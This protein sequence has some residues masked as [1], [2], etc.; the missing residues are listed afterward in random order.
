MKFSAYI[1]VIAASALLCAPVKAQDHTVSISMTG[2]TK[3]EIP[4]GEIAKIEF[5]PRS[6]PKGKLK[7]MWID[8]EANFERLTTRAAID[9]ELNK[10]KS[11]GYAMYRSDFLPYCDVFGDKS[12]TR[13]YDDYLGYFL[14]R[15]EAI[16]LD[17]VASMGA[18]CWGVQT[19]N[20]VRQGLIFDQWDKWGD[21]VQVR[22]DE[23]NP[24]LIV[25]ITD[26]LSQPLALLDP[27]FPEV[28]ELILKTVGEIVTKY[29]KLKGIC[30]DYLRYNNNEGGW[31]G[32]GEANLKGYAEYWNE[33]APHHLD[34][35]TAEGGVG[36]CFTKW[37]EY[38]S[39][40]ITE[41]LGKI[42]QTVKSIRPECELQ[43]WASAEWT[44]RYSVGQNWASK[45]Y[46]PWGFAYT[47]TYSRTGFADL[48]DVFITGAYT[49]NV[50]IEDAPAGSA[51]S[52]ENFCKTTPDYLM[53]DCRCYG[54]I[55]TYALTPSQMTD[56]TY[57]CLK[58]TEGYINFE[59]SHT[60]YG[61]KWDATAEG[62]DKY[63]SETEQDNY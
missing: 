46:K 11:H 57:L 61:N 55:A 54:S 33:P 4:T 8:V 30:L 49:E 43:L 56:A 62:I 2:G 41:L 18:T 28:Q 12:V 22:S 40:L 58:H 51:W 38:R 45:N 16:G 21:K 17:V 60:N 37:I 15:C 25:P 13:D 52:V 32:M 9:E 5:T 10:I 59:L 24:D 36:D 7:A 23:N 63:E 20:G 42:R 6:E 39:A 48:L 50:W 14:E 3:V 44:S 31:Y 19:R 1:C 47:D 29:P 53:G 27:V 34:V 26:D 35:V